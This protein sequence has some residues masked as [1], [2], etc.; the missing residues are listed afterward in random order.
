MEHPVMA[1]MR[2]P[3]G[4]LRAQAAARAPL[5]ASDFIASVGGPLARAAADAVVMPTP[6]PLP[7]ALLE[8][9]SHLLLGAAGDTQLRVGDSAFTLAPFVTAAPPPAQRVYAPLQGDALHA[10]LQFTPRP[11]C[12]LRDADKGQLP[13]L[14]PPL[15]FAD[16][17]VPKK[18]KKERTE[19]DKKRVRRLHY[20]LAHLAGGVPA[21]VLCRNS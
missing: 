4:A 14:P 1:L 21:D 13:T 15:L 18:V 20:A 17:H 12:A 7:P 6:A 9:H 10:A 5:G 2:D 19:E 8:P 16:V 11:D 3:L